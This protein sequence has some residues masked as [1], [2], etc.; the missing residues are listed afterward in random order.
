MRFLALFTALLL[1]P[2]FAFAQPEAAEDILNEEVTPAQ[3]VQ[4]ATTASGDSVFYVPNGEWAIRETVPNDDAIRWHC[5]V[6]SEPTLTGCAAHMDS[7][8]SVL[9]EPPTQY[10]ADWCLHADTQTHQIDNATIHAPSLSV[11]QPGDT[12]AIV[13]ENGKCAGYG[14]YSAEGVTF[15][16]H[17]SD[18]LEDTPNGFEGGEQVGWVEV[19]HT[20]YEPTWAACDTLDVPVCRENTYED[21]GFHQIAPL[22][23]PQ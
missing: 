11:A 20:R 16:A 5:Q 19:A 23:P 15:A 14:T 22:S 21:G 4:I 13:T 2:A 18:M 8:M 1:L 17:G 12:V 10:Y 9:T 6:P 7:L 3:L